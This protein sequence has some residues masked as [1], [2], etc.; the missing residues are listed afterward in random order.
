M[1]LLLQ[2]SRLVL[3]STASCMHCVHACCSA[4]LGA[5]ALCRNADPAVRALQQLEQQQGAAIAHFSCSCSRAM[6]EMEATHSSTSWAVAPSLQ[7]SSASSMLPCSCT[8]SSEE[9]TSMPAAGAEQ[10]SGGGQQVVAQCR[11]SHA[12]MSAVHG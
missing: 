1:P 9:A 8:V 2:G 5:L 11:Q 6:A 12:G 10:G 3:H 7:A 4:A